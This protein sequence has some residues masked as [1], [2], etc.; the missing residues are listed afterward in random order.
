MNKQESEKQIKRLVEKYESLTSTERNKYNEARTCSEF[1]IPLFQALGWDIHNT[2]STEVTPETSVSG[3]SADYAFS[4]NGVI[5][6]FLE[7]KKFSVDLREERWSEQAVFYAYHKSVPYAV[8]TDFE[9]I[10]VYCSEWDESDVERSLILEI[11]YKD[12]LTNEK[13]WLLSKESIEGGDLDKYAE[14]NRKKPKREPVDKQLAEDLLQWRKMLFDNLKSWNSD[15]HLTQKQLAESV[16]VLLNRLIFIRTTEDRKIEGERL[17]EFVRTYEDNKAKVE[18]YKEFKKLFESYNE[19]YDSRLFET[20]QIIDTLEYDNETITKV[21]NELYKNKKGIRYDFASI[22]ADVLGSIYEQYLGH[23]QHEEKDSKKSKR[24]SQG[25]YYTPRYIVDYIT[26]NTLGEVLKGISAYKASK[27]TVCDPACGSGSF[28][29]R[30]FEILD[31][32]AKREKNQKGLDSAIN[33]ARKIQILTSNIYGVDLDN[34]A[35]EIARLNLLLRVV[36]MRSHLPSL[37]NNIECGNSLI[38]GTEKDLEKFL[39]KNW[40]DKKPFNWKGEF[41]EVFKQGGFDA[42]IGNPPYIKEY[43]DKSAFDG[44][45]DSPYYQGK[46]DIWTLFACQAIDHLKNGGY[47]SFIAPNSWLTNTGASVFRNKILKEG[48]IISFIDFGDFKVFKDAGIQTMIFIFQKKKPRSKYLV[49]YIKILN[50]EI[51]EEKV[52]EFLNSSLTNTSDDVEHYQIQF[53]PEKYF[54]KTLSF[55]GSDKGNVIDQI[56]A[57]ANFKLTDKE[58]AQGIVP[59]PDVINSRNI[60][61]IKDIDIVK[62]GIKIGKGVFVINKNELIVGGGEEDFI[63]PLYDTKEIG[64]YFFNKQNTKEIIY[65]PKGIKLPTDSKILDHLKKFRPIM[66]KRRENLSGQIAFFNLH[67][68]RDKRFFEEGPKIISARKCSMPSFSFTNNEAYVMLT[69]NIIKTDRINLKY[70]TAILNSRVAYF[71]LKS[72]GKTQGDNLQID[73]EPLLNFPIYMTNSKEKQKRIVDLVEEIIDLIKKL[74][75]LDPILDK[76][77]YDE[78]S[79]KIALKEQEIDKEIYKLYGLSPEEITIIESGTGKK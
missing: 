61:D 41:S 45:H 2:Y 34:E 27:I 31:E 20:G 28:L 3:K 72:R 18:L 13:L 69:F 38:S 25:I 65:I 30:A 59:N 56:E 55:F 35:V 70:L 63:K 67:W 21:I 48:E 37:V 50:S 68:P 62:F 44:L 14:E 43:V 9:S 7:A 46:M 36:E 24:K 71:W 57:A 66:E 77:L 1:I 78:N 5:K 16:Q 8:L 39:G 52:V 74:V 60:K 33:Y 10:K 51:A 15:K 6:F 32:H 19:W 4:L 29:I 47:F 76:E 49:E 58:I 22:N 75:L 17:R 40:R 11:S 53:E 64:R 26:R 79:N 42:I 12:Y 23:I 73:K 54:D